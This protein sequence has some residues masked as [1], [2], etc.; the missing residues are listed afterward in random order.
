MQWKTQVVPVKVLVLRRGHTHQYTL[1]ISPLNQFNQFSITYSHFE[2]LET[3]SRDH[4]YAAPVSSL[5]STVNASA[6]VGGDD[7]VTKQ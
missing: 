3:L 7:Q 5:G 2:K 6:D 4:N 1:K